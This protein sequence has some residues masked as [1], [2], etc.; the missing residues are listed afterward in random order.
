LRKKVELGG[1]ER[2]LGK[3][4][5]REEVFGRHENIKYIVGMDAQLCEN[6]KSHWIVYF[7]RLNS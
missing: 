5:R 1:T 7:K 2:S 6:A 4:L 3:W